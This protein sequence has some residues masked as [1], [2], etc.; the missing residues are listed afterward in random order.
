VVG[1]AERVQV[2]LFADF[3]PSMPRIVAQPFLLG[4]TVGVVRLSENRYLHH[5]PGGMG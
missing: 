1:R 2:L 5:L 3:D 4:R